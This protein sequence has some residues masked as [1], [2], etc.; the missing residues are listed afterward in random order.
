MKSAK[1]IQCLTNKINEAIGITMKDI[2]HNHFF[3]KA[4]E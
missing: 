2:D 1:E 3:S 4:K